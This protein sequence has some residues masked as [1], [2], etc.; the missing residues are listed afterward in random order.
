MVV[1]RRHA[2]PCES[3][4]RMDPRC[5]CP[6]HPDYRVNGKR[7]RRTLKT[8]NW[9]RAIADAR[10]KELEGFK[11]KPKSP[12][13]EQACDKFLAD[14]K[15]R[16]LREATLYKFRLLFRQLQDFAK[17]KGL[18]YMSD[19]HLDNVRDFRATWPNKNESARAKL[20]N[21]RRFSAS[22]LNLNGWKKIMRL[23]SSLR[24]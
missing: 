23:T 7:F 17:S 18:V 19:F 14:A 15:A 24:K 6:I 9:Q 21:L 11:E 12:T 1:W 3:T 10:Q 22:A 8:T 4:D 16:E 5:G 13:V 20:G 2:P